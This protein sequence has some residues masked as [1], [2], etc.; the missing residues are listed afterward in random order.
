MQEISRKLENYYQIATLHVKFHVKQPN[1]TG[2]NY[3]CFAARQ[4][5]PISVII[6]TMISLTIDSS[7]GAV[8]DYCR[9]YFNY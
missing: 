7:L 6:F 5:P 3:K 8:V 1:N 2:Y 4:P 9:W